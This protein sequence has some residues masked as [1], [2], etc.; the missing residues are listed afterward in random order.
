M[1]GSESKLIKYMEGADKRFVIPVYQRNYDWMIENCKQLYDDLIKVVRNGRKN[2]FFGS[3]VSTFN[4]DGDN[5]EYQIIDGQQRLTTV[6]LLLLAMYNLIKQGKMVPEDKRLSDRIY[7]DYLVDKYQ[8]EETRI[9]LKPIKNDRRAF[10]KLFDDEEEHI[11]GSNLTTNYNYFYDRIQ[12]EEIS[13]DQLFQAIRSLEII[14]IRLDTDD[15]PQLIFESL[16]STGL[17]LSEGDKIRNYILMGL[18]AKQQEVFYEKYWNKIEENT[19]YQ[20]DLFVRDYL[21]VKQQATPSLSKIYFTF[22]GYVEN[23]ELDT[24]TL[25]IDLLDYA[26][27]YRILLT[28]KVGDKRLGSCI[29][30]LNRLETT[31]TRPFFLEILRLNKEGTFSMDDVVDVFL[32]TENYLFRRTICELPTNQLNKIFLLLHKEVI[33]YDGTA[34]NY[35]EKLKYALLSKK[36]RARFPED[37]EF[38]DTFAAKQIYSMNAKNKMYI[39]ERF[40]NFGTIEDKD[41]YRH[42]DDGDYSIE[43]IMPQHLTPA[44]ADVLGDDYERIHETWLHRMA[45]L[46]LTGYNSKYSNNTFIE[47]RDMANGFKD[48]GIRM[49]QWIGA[50]AQWTEEELEKRNDYVQ[51]RALEIWA[52]PVTSFRP[53]EKQLDSCTLDD[54]IDLTGRKIARFAYLTMEQPVKNWAEMFESVV[55]LLHSEDKSVLNNLAYETDESVDLS[56]YVSYKKDALRGYIEIDNGIYVERNT[57]TWTKLSILKRLFSLYKLDASDLVFYLR[58]EDGTDEEEEIAGTRYE[59]RKNFW[60]YALEIIREA[61]KESGAF[62]NCNPVIE[63]WMNGYFGIQGFYLCT[64][65][66][67][68]AVRAELVFGKASSEENKKGFDIVAAHKAEIE[69]AI[70]APLV[71]D[72]GDD[73]KSSKIYFTLDGVGIGKEEDWPVIARFH[74]KWTAKLYEAIVVPYL[75]P[76]YIAD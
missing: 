19:N 23:D 75:K 14:N 27:L 74:A 10:G 59:L 20:V 35:L 7:E 16:N 22:K 4:P 18:P 5:E 41:V 3:I 55:R 50:Q 15:N 37:V 71:W 21:S 66:N 30:R 43:H 2:H 24:E 25:L 40:E 76:V 9:K 45:N 36:E 65:A 26:R 62:S 34:D 28:G 69:A 47:K 53:I 8:P 73:K 54:E 72:R 64:V 17:D 68:D 6:S 51:Q 49:N 61:N 13:I 44:W 31:V 56:S 39:L 11:G 52:V 32:T 57:S 67:F 70:G 1:K 29:Y 38:A 58:D 46:T 33:R 12:K 63:N 42:F 48:S 60:T